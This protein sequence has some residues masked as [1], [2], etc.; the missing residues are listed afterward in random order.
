MIVVKGAENA[1]S[2]AGRLAATGDAIDGETAALVDQAMGE[3]WEAARAYEPPPLPSY[4]RTGRL[5]SSWQLAKQGNRWTLGSDA[6]YA[7]FV[8]GH[9]SGEGQAWMHVGRWRPLS[10]I[11]GRAL[12]LRDALVARLRAALGKRD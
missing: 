2:A 3:A 4:R 9:P 7:R 6:P 1:I 5:A 10:D 8:R 11:A 12:D